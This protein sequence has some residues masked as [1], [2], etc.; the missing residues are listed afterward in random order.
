MPGQFIVSYDS[1]N[2]HFTLGLVLSL[3]CETRQKYYIINKV[4]SVITL[5][6]IIILQ[7]F[8]TKKLFVKGK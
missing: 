3:I 2:V 4:F 8:I 6:F 5:D 7:L 1:S